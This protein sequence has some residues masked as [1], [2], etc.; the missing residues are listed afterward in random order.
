MTIL[1]F[2]GFNWNPA[3]GADVGNCGKIQIRIKNLL[4]H[5]LFKMVRYVFLR[6][7]CTEAGARWPRFGL[8]VV[9]TTSCRDNKVQMIRSLVVLSGT[10]WY[11]FLDGGFR[12][13]FFL[14]F[15]SLVFLFSPM[16]RA[17]VVVFRFIPGAGGPPP[18]PVF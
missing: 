4:G 8:V 9:A 7:P 16:H 13:T 3:E 6:P 17:G 15:V 10:K 12:F 2:I 18:P 1:C 14:L 11:D 5:A